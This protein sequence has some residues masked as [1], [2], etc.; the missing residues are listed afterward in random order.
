MLALLFDLGA[1]S[2]LIAG[3]ALLTHRAMRDRAAGERAAFL[4]ATL[5]ALLALPF[6]ALLLPA[7][8]LAWLPE[9]SA[10]STVMAPLLPSAALRTAP[11][12]VTSAFSWEEL[13]LALYC[14]GVTVLLLRFAIGVWTLRRWKL[15]A[16][17]AI[18]PRWQGVLARETA[19]L[20]RPVRL[21]VSPHAGTPVSWGVFPAIILIGPATHDLPEQAEAVIAHE[22]AHIRRFDWL[23]LVLARL[24]TAL[25]WFNPLAWLVVRELSRETELAADAEALRYVSRHDYAEALLSVANSRQAHR[26]ALG[27]AIT[28]TALAG[29]ITAALDGKVSPRLRPRARAALLLLALATAGPLAATQIVAAAHL[30][31]RSPRPAPPLAPEPSPEAPRPPEPQSG[32]PVPATDQPSA[33]LL[34]YPA[35]T[36]PSMGSQAAIVPNPRPSA[37]VSVVPAPGVTRI[38]SPTDG[39]VVV[40]PQG[41]SIIDSR[42]GARVI[43]GPNG[44][45][46]N[47]AG[48]SEQGEGRRD[49]IEDQR[50]NLRESAA[51]LRAQ[52]D[53]MER[54]ARDPNHLP[55]EMLAQNLGRVRDMRAKAV[56]L[57]DQAARLT[58]N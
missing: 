54:K 41:A 50:E 31:P 9:H 48:Q 46:L 37:V 21:L 20:R 58:D 15:H 44:V 29:R 52:A 25:F 5:V 30:L 47:S 36:V 49:A 10:A 16:Q 1:K 53:G 6:F 55:P 34:N 27:M 19:T 7:I 43:F 33:D 57:D 17:P 28:R 39:Q 45:T 4:Q 3:I 40:G 42:T 12:E 2:T 38:V 13:S 32:A 23:A 11:A 56:S 18:D 8:D 24:T 26:E 51:D 14:A 22:M 35:P